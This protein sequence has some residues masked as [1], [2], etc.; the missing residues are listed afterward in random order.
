MSHF[1]PESPRLVVS[2]G[3]HVT[4]CRFGESRPLCS[5]PL[6]GS[7]TFWELYR[8]LII[9]YQGTYLH[10]PSEFWEPTISGIFSPAPIFA[11]VL[12]KILVDSRDWIQVALLWPR[13]PWFTELLL[14]SRGDFVQFLA[15][16]DL[17]DQGGSLY[18]NVKRLHLTVWRTGCSMATNRAFPLGGDSIAECMP[19]ID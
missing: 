4:P 2:K 13:L 14:L 16:R 7:K 10:H 9:S 5:Q 17:L 19:A 6:G 1:Y 15:V 11:R 12:E 8:T 18:P 3:S